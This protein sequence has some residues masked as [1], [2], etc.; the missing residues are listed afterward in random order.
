MRRSM[1]TML[2]ALLLAACL[3][4]SL[5]AGGKQ[6]A[7]TTGEAAATQ[8][9][10]E[11]GE[12][13]MLAELVQRGE[14][15]PVEERLPEDV[16]VLEPVEEI[17]QYGGTWRRVANG[18]GHGTLKMIMYD[19]PVRWNRD[20]TGYEPNLFKS[21]EYNS[22]GTAVTFFLRNGVK[23]SD[24]E[25]FT[26]DDIRFWWE[27]LAQNEDFGDVGV[28]GWAFLKGE[29]MTVDFVDDYTIRFNFAH[30][31]WLLPYTIAQG[32]WVWEPMMAP[33][34]YLENFHPAYNSDI[35]D[36]YTQLGEKRLWHQNPEHPVLFAWR[37]IE[38]EAGV[39]L[40]VERNPYYWK[41][42]TAG[43]QLPYIDRIVSEEVTDPE[44]RLLKLIA[45]EIDASWRTGTSS[46]LDIPVLLEAADEANIRYM[47]GFVAGEGSAPGILINQNFAENEYVRGLLQNKYF[48][49]AL[50]H[51]IDR[52]HINDVVW[53]GM[54]E[55][56]GGTTA[57]KEAIHFQSPEGKRVYEEWQN[58]YTEYD[59]SLANDLLEQVGLTER[60]PSTGYRLRQDNGE[61]LE[62]IITDSAPLSTPGGAFLG[63]IENY[64]EEIGLK[65]T[66]DVVPSATASHRTEE[67]LYHFFIWWGEPQDGLSEL[68]LFTYPEN[69]FVTGLY[70]RNWPLEGRW[71]ATGG[72]E[73]WEPGPIAEGLYDLYTAALAEPDM[74]ERHKYV[75]QAIRDY[76]VDEGPF[77]IAATRGLPMPVFVKKNFRNVPNYGILSPW[78]PASPGSQDPSQFFFKQ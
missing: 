61:V 27:D 54:G 12:A 13:P 7:G 35:G 50:S 78:A 22:D 46:A 49:R 68:D 55:I 48:R 9:A 59:V 40:I 36:D 53:Q 2:L 41:V 15:P 56:T 75:H 30:P 26:T 24:G 3:P 32:F 31:N 51:S 73:G 69:V 25:P 62:L 64:W 60:D 76:W 21:W 52:D 42:D 14:L 58:A 29:Q 17:G 37:P 44:V 1:V 43:N 77:H 20:L 65:T 11:G 74:D 6:E 63:L 8:Q 47:S 28:P 10:A 67:G 57:T 19:V 71:F 72:K 18:P 38:F 5:F 66:I 45:G 34:H 16:L 33:R 39:N 70:S 4:L 23:W